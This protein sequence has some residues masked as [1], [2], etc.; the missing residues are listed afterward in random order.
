MHLAGV[1][2][3][4]ESALPLE[5]LNSSLGPPKLMRSWKQRGTD[6]TV[7]QAP[8]EPQ[9]PVL[10]AALAQSGVAACQLSEGQSKHLGARA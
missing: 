4:P 10:T 2:G 9:V 6:S 8:G 7:L 5:R 3:A 1:L